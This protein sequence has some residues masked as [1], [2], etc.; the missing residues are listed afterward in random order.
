MDG[1]L[2]HL[3]SSSAIAVHHCAASAA[4]YLVVAAYFRVFEFVLVAMEAAR[5]IHTLERA[6]AELAS[7]LGR[8]R[9]ELSEVVDEYQCL[10]RE[11]E[12]ASEASRK[13]ARA[14]ADV[15]RSSF[16]ALRAIWAVHTGASH[17]DF[18]TVFVA[19]LSQQA[20]VRDALLAAG[21]HEYVAL[22]SEGDISDLIAAIQAFTPDTVQRRERAELSTAVQELGVDRVRMEAASN[23]LQS[24]VADLQRQLKEGRA[25]ESALQDALSQSRAEHNIARKMVGSYVLMDGDRQCTAEDVVKLEAELR[26]LHVEISSLGAQA[27]GRGIDG[28]DGDEASALVAAIAQESAGYLTRA[29]E[30]EARA[31]ALASQLTMAS[32]THDTALSVLRT[33]TQAV[34]SSTATLTRTVATLRHELEILQDKYSAREGVVD[35][36]RQELTDAHA[37][38]SKLQAHKTAIAQKAAL[39]L[40]EVEG[41]VHSLT[42]AVHAMKGG[43]AGA[44]P[45]LTRA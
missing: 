8:V 1:G 37:R 23:E 35:M 20:T 28:V 41:Q 10:E 29:T 7:E 19:A 14:L 33:E 38:L 11:S 27:A 24:T 40:R 12:T 3:R 34:E 44:Q 18:Q 31:E 25:R 21:Q 30:A 16:A 4:T 42:A 17:E 26:H 5:R 9:G 2:F 22:A 13:L 6:N 36:L 15:S 45:F 39:A 32:L 43:S